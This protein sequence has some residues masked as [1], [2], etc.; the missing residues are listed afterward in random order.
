MGL[1][2]GRTQAAKFTFNHELLIANFEFFPLPAESGKLKKWLF[3]RGL[4]FAP[5]LYVLP[6]Y[7]EPPMAMTWKMVLKFC[8]EMFFG[9]DL[10]FFDDSHQWCLTYWHEDR[11]FWGSRIRE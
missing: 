4:P 3:Q 5:W 1:L 6:N 7:G 11:L 2:S 10:V 8:E 9:D